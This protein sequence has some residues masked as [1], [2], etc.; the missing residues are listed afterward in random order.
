[1][2]S[3]KMPELTAEQLVDLQV[4]QD[5]RISPSGKHCVYVCKPIARA[6]EHFISSLWIAELGKEHSA[7]QLTSGLSHD[8]SPRWCP[9][10]TTGESIAFISDRAKPGESSAIYVLSMDGGEAYPVTKVGG[11]KA[12]EAFKWSPDGQCIAFLSAD[13]KSKDQETREEET[14][15]AIV[16]G[17][18]WEFDRLRLLHVA[19]RE[20]STLVADDVSELPRWRGGISERCDMLPVDIQNTRVH[21]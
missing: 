5:V 18:D 2:Y 21:E 4:P 9:D 17:E 15:G 14:G 20:I 13:E 10:T 8:S 19:T 6:A 7:R 11:K 3:T 12:I 1:M 16:Y